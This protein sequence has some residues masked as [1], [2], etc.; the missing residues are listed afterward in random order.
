MAAAG[1]CLRSGGFWARRLDG[2]EVEVPELLALELTL[3]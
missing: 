2:K 1:V 3:N